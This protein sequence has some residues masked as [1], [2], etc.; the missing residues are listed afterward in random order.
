MHE[1]CDKCGRPVPPENNA[2]NVAV[3]TGANELLMVFASP[4]HFLPVV[5]CGQQ[6]CPGSPSR[7]QYIEGQPRDTRGLYPYNPDYE[8]V[9]RPAYAKVLAN[10]AG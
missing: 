5:E 2:I 4:R 1:N 3:E 6:I 10:A 9:F 7:A 8:Q